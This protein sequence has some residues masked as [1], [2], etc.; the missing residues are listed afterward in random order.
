MF[1]PHE[2]KT[3]VQGV[4]KIYISDKAYH[5]M[6]FMVDEVSDEVG[7]LGTVKQDNFLTFC[8]EEVF[9]VEQEVTAAMTELDETGMAKLAEE[10]MKRPN[11]DAYNR[12]RFWGHSHVRMDVQPS[13][14]DNKQMELF[15]KNGC[16]F[17]IRGI[18]NKLGKAKFDVYY[19]KHGMIFEDCT[20]EMVKMKDDPRRKHWQEQIKDKVKKYVAPPT[21]AY[22]GGLPPYGGYGYAGYV[23]GDSDSFERVSRYT[24]PYS[25][26]TESTR[27]PLQLN[28]EFDKLARD[29]AKQNL[30]KMGVVVIEDDIITEDPKVVN[31]LLNKARNPKSPKTG[32]KSEIIVPKGKSFYPPTTPPVVTPVVTPT[33]PTTPSGTDTQPLYET[34]DD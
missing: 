21:V 5:D 22:A 32:G 26:R 33:S 9:L 12:L 13:G 17:F 31:D 15:E 16:E 6:W 34:W 19:F 25:R 1:I 28:K 27:T 24:S 20:W 8:I 29:E 30:E 11:D 18:F 10:L 3:T 4:P 2:F 23:Y 7:W 14:Q